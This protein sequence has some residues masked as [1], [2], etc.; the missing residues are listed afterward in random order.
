M[1]ALGDTGV[2][3]GD[4]DGQAEVAAA[5]TAEDAADPVDGLVLLGDLFYPNGLEADRVIERVAHNIVDPYCA[6]IAPGP[7]YAELETTCPLAPASNPDRAV[8]AVLGNHDHG[9]S[10]SAALQRDV[11]PAF[12]ANWHMNRAVVEVVEAAPGVSLILVDTQS[13]LAGDAQQL[14]DAVARAAGPWRIL[15]GHHPFADGLGDRDGVGEATR[16]MAAAARSAGVPVQLALSGH[17][18]NLQ[19]FVS[20]VPALQIISGGGSG[21]RNLHDEPLPRVFGLER[22]GFARVAVLATYP[23]TLRVE[24][25]A[26]SRLSWLLSPRRVATYFVALDGSVTDSTGS[27]VSP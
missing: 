27:S 18:H 2:P 19:A 21:S 11:L 13:L 14:A 25:I 15:V 5:L 10:G 17:E 24:L 20:D 8:W 26:L 4:H 16:A 7:R 23:E 22:P 3:P 12:V 1:L 9:F 6:L